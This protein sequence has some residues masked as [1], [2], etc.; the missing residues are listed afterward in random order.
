ME[1]WQTA[2]SV[3]DILVLLS[4]DLYQVVSD[5]TTCLPLSFHQT[6]FSLPLSLVTLDLTRALTT[7]SNGKY[8]ERLARKQACGRI[9]LDASGLI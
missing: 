9:L 3:F 7:D 5:P 4:L 8:V 2:I 1:N 6:P